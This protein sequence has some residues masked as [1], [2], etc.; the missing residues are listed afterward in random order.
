MKNQMCDDA[1]LIIWIGII[2]THN[3]NAVVMKMPLIKMHSGC[4][5]K[6]NF[7]LVHFQVRKYLFKSK[8]G[9][10][11]N[12]R[13]LCFILLSKLVKLHNLLWYIYSIVF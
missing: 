12:S 1:K 4:T 11:G 5:V 10:I 7:M 13:Y 9:W 2:Y 3:L 6:A 8:R